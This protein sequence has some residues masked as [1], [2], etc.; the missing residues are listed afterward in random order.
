MVAI[1]VA[2]I[3]L[4]SYESSYSG[5]PQ[6]VVWVALFYG[7]PLMLVAG[8]PLWLWCKG[9]FAITWFKVLVSGSICGLLIPMLLYVPILLSSFITR[10]VW[11][12]NEVLLVLLAMALGG[13]LLGAAIAV[14]FR[15]L[16]GA[17]TP[18]TR[19]VA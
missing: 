5:G 15:L 7:Y 6:F 9:R 14:V 3:A 8:V 17:P 4:F 16:A 2:G 10:N 11:H 19:K 12:T 1:I 13:A 18:P